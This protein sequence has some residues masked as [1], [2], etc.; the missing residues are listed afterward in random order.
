MHETPSRLSFCKKNKNKKSQYFSF[1]FGNVLTFCK[2][3]N[4]IIKTFIIK[5]LDMLQVIYKNPASEFCCFHKFKLQNPTVSIK[6]P[7]F[8][9]IM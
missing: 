4:L 2:F 5:P 7:C 9:V 3:Q 8:C 1:Y 6:I